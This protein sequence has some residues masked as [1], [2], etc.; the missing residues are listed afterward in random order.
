MI[1]ECFMSSTGI[2]ELIR[3]AQ[4]LLYTQVIFESS[5]FFA[6]CQLINCEM[7]SEQDLFDICW[8]SIRRWKVK[9][10]KKDRQ[11]QRFFRLHWTK[12]FFSSFAIK[13]LNYSVESFF[14]LK[15][16]SLVFFYMQMAFSLVHIYTN[17][18][19]FRI[20]IVIIVQLSSTFLFTLF[21]VVS[22]S[23]LLNY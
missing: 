19:A 23:F 8:N 7:S 18:F 20:I 10:E 6:L 22:P 13:K 1:R 2:I 12:G 11:Q 4:P 16:S 21:F 5:L 17:I 15:S 3:M 14:Y 9:R